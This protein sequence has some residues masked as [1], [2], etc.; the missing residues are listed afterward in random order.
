MRNITTAQN[1]VWFLPFAIIFIYLD[2]LSFTLKLMKLIKWPKVKIQ[3][4]FSMFIKTLTIVI[5]KKLMQ[6]YF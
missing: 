1:Q 2:A 4:Q 3:P 6:D 5:I